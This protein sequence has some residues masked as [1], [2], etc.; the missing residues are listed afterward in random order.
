MEYVILLG[1]DP[2]TPVLDD[3]MADVVWQALKALTDDV[4]MPRG[5]MVNA[6][7]CL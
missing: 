1:A 2:R 4:S 6:R 7:N 3:N 5:Q